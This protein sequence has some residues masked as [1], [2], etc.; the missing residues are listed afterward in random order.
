MEKMLTRSDRGNKIAAARRNPLTAAIL[1]LIIGTSLL[2]SLPAG[3]S[4]EADGL[5][6]CLLILHCC[7]IRKYYTKN[8]KI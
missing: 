8:V 1:L 6:P 4:A 7:L 5:L 2:V 3:N